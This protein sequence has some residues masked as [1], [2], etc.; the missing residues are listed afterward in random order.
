MS[1]SNAKT[2]QTQAS[3]PFGRFV[4]SSYRKPL[5]KH[6][7][8]SLLPIPINPPL[9]YERQQRNWDLDTFPS[10]GL[11]DHPIIA[12][13]SPAYEAPAPIEL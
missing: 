3:I 10:S 9:I 1:E 8:D 6:R 4:D 7:S 12:L 13:S 11:T 2:H 5:G